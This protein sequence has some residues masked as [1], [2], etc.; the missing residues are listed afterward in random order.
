MVDQSEKIAL[1]IP[2]KYCL[3]MICDWTAMSRQFGDT[4]IEFFNKNRHKMVL[5][6]KTVAMIEKE[7]SE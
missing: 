4:P 1:P 5:H 3:E 6:P 2:E 7:L